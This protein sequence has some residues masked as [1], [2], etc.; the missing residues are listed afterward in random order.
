MRPLFLSTAVLACACSIPEPAP[1]ALGEPTLKLFTH[2]EDDEALVGAYVNSLESF[3]TTL[4]LEGQLNDRTFTP[5]ILTE[6]DLGGAPLPDG[7]DPQEQ[8]PIAVA[9][10]SV[11][12]VQASIDLAMEP[13]HVCIES[14]TT[15]YYARTITEGA[16]CFGSAECSFL[17]TT[18]EVRKESI[19]D[20]WYD[21]FKDFRLV[22]L[23]DGRVAML[24]RSWM[25][26]QFFTDN[27]K[28]VLEQTF[29]LE[30]WIP[31]SE[32]P[33]RTLRYY[34]MWSSADLLIDDDAIYS[35]LVKGGMDQGMEYADSYLAG[36]ENYCSNDRDREYD[37]PT[38]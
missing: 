23:E 33:A 10:V 38:E 8:V 31:S 20:V 18:N 26:K 17:R 3:L 9:G 21:L 29:T 6:A 22:T 15:K 1:E 28:D 13:N 27:G 34:S 25:D 30:A 4:D 5:G 24:S 19:S 35:T 2:F 32:D 14:A 12:P 36:E 7:A 16:D 37:R 11:H